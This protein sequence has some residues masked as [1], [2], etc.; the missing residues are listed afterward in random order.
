LQI[1]YSEELTIA[2]IAL[3]MALKAYLERICQYRN[4]RMSS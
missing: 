1:K 2:L 3:G 4:A